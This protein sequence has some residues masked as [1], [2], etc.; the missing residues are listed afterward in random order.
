MI[1]VLQGDITKIRGFDAIVNSAN[2]SL[3]GGGG[4]DGQ[5]HR[6]AGPQ[7]RTECRK[8]NGCETGE[9][10]ITLGYNLPCSHVIHSVGPVWMGGTAGEDD[11]LKSCYKS[12]MK[13]ALSN[14]LRKIAI[15]PISAGEYGYP[16]ELASKIALPIIA[17]FVSKNYDAFD[18]ICFVVADENSE[19]I[20]AEQ[21]ELNP[22][23]KP[24]PRKKA[25]SKKKSSKK[26]AQN[27][28]NEDSKDE[29]IPGNTETEASESANSE[30]ENVEGIPNESQVKASENANSEA[31][32]VEE[33]PNDSEVKAS[34]SAD[35]A[36]TH[37]DDIP[38]S[39][40]SI[41]V[42]ESEKD[43]SATGSDSD[44][45]NE[46]I[47]AAKEGSI[48]TSD[49]TPQ[50]TTGE[51]EEKKIND[52]ADEPAISFQIPDS[53][54]TKPWDLYNI[55]WLIAEEAAGT[56]HT[57]T[58]FWHANEGSEN[59]ILSHWYRGTPLYIHGRK[60]STV[61]QYLMSEKALMF[62][63]FGSYKLIMEEPD[64]AKCKKYGRNIQ[65]YDEDAWN[66]VF[67]ETIFFGNLGKAL[68]DK[69]FADALIATNDAVLVEA[70]P[71]D[72]IYGAGLKKN[73]L[74][75]PDGNLL[76]PPEKWRAYKSERQAQNHLGFV[77]MAV[78]DYIK[79]F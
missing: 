13:I 63:D 39:D 53:G 43:I 70:S 48:E 61:E 34:E 9:S 46:E 51:T 7:L 73:D 18:D 35:N 17:D 31:E 64:P 15:S 3:L 36:E 54:L 40:D 21:I 47:D 8:L 75:S 67:R 20:Y 26:P 5:I 27:T 57:Y 58:C 45:S 11:L 68:C 28:D 1:R 79:K 41:A 37:S 30:T 62:D 44:S 10:R 12:I 76:I 24:E 60:Y 14:K 66:K 29:E 42:N 71:F 4:I 74:L 50:T 72:D 6:A 69:K 33:I 52:N 77:L 32:S 22:V 2:N 59:N 65:N 38:D 23:K 56:S 19:S 25:E 16:A 78:R 49:K 55:D